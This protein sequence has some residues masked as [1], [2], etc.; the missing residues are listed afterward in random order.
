[1][2]HGIAAIVAAVVAL[3]LSARGQSPVLALVGV[4]VIPMD[5]ER[6]LERQ[7]LV[8]RDGRIAE[9]GPMA[10]VRPPAGAQIV[11]G[12]GKYVIPALGEMH[13][14]LAGPNAEHERAHPRAQRRS[15][16]C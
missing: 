4:H 5:R 2:R 8:I 11:N 6:V 16:A 15:T 3:G 9:M 7:T 13:G 10:S 1:M 12:A 14:H